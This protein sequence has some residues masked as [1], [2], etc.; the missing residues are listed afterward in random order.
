MK[1]TFLRYLLITHKIGA[2]VLSQLIYSNNKSINVI[3]YIIIQ[4]IAW[5]ELL[6]FLFA[7][8]LV[9]TVK[10]TV[11]THTIIVNYYSRVYLIKYFLSLFWV[12][13]L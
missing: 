2:K 12:L 13:Q 9:N 4:N 7:L 11:L 8:L 5:I 6:R 10:L 1:Y 3:L